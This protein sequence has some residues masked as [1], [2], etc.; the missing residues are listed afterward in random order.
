MRAILVSRP[1]N[2]P[3]SDDE[4][5]DLRIISSLEEVGPLH[6]SSQ[7]ELPQPSR[8]ELHLPTQPVPH[9]PSLGL[10]LGVALGSFTADGDFT[11]NAF[12]FGDYLADH[13]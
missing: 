2:P 5:A 6:P 13:P 8:P 7:L 12:N 11:E 3:L 10:G 1:G 4:T 9:M